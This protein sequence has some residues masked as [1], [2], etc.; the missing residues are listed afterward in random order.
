MLDLQIFSHLDLSVS[1]YIEEAIN[2]KDITIKKFIIVEWHAYTGNENSR[3]E[4]VFK[5]INKNFEKRD[6]LEVK[7]GRDKILSQG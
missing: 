6:C 5:K 3:W 4:K 2:I 1:Q 7:Y